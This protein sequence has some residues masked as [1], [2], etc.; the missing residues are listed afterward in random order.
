MHWLLQQNL[1]TEEQLVPYITGLDAIKSLGATWSFIKLVPFAG[2]VI[3]DID[4]TG[5]K[6]FA[7]GSTSLILGSQKRGWTPGVIFNENFRYEAWLK[8]YGAKNMLNGDGVV[9]KFGD[10]LPFKVGKCFVRPCEDL[11]AFTGQVFEMQALADWQK[12]VIGGEVSTRSLQLTCETP[13]VIAQTKFIYREWRFFVVGGRV[14]SGSQ[15]RDAY[16]RRDDADVDEDVWKFAQKMVDRWQPGDCFVI[17]IASTE[18][19]LKVI[20]INCFNGSGLY[21][22]D[23]AKI[24]TAVENFYEN[25][26]QSK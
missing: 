23:T 3:P 25:P 15:Y 11:K 21:K 10:P 20:E 7:L 18:D 24:F 8:G 16:G 14:I 2:D 17:D 9:Q 1:S 4:Y 5:K 26:S 22:C 13:I 19:S 6:V 12:S